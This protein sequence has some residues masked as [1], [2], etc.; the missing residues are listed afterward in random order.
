[1]KRKISL[2]QR[3][4]EKMLGRKFYI[5]IV[6]TKGSNKYFVNSDIYRTKQAAIDYQKHIESECP[7][8]LF[9]GIYSFRSKNDFFLKMSVKDFKPI[10]E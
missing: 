9:I 4:V 3:I 2:I 6:G 7:S 5:C 8:L 10:T 1:M